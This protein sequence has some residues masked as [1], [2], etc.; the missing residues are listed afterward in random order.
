MFKPMHLHE[1]NFAKLC[2]RK[3]V[4]S[5]TTSAVQ[6]AVGRA[7]IVMKH[8]LL[9]CKRAVNGLSACNQIEPKSSR[10]GIGFGKR[11][12]WAPGPRKSARYGLFVETARPDE[13]N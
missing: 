13:T 5:S 7:G 11:S 2:T 6:T 1:L 3:A 4:A 12:W 10:H 8:K 9:V